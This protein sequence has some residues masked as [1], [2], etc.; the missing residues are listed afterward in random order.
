V[1]KG[2]DTLAMLFA[3]LFARTVPNQSEIGHRWPH[4]QLSE[5]LIT[6][7]PA[8]QLGHPAVGIFQVAEHDRLR[9]TGL[10]A[11]RLD[12]TIAGK[13]ARFALGILDSLHAEGAF[14]HDAAR[15]HGHIRVQGQILQKIVMSV[16]KP[17]EAPYLVR[18]VIGAVARADAAV[19]D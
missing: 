10:L 8:G 19:I 18:T 6:A 9:G 16:I 4:V 2:T 14:L 5:D 15:P 1:S 17:I 11:S 12:D 3:L 7:P 13:P